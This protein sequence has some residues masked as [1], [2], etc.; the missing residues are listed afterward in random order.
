MLLRSYPVAIRRRR[1]SLLNVRSI[2]FRSRYSSRSYSQGSFR[3]TLA[4]MTVVAPPDWINA[5]I[6]V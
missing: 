3:L 2:R 4:D 6:F 5:R 1:F